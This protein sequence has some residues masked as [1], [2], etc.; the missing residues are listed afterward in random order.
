LYI[1]SDTNITDD[2]PP[3][4]AGGVSSAI[5]WPGGFWMTHSRVNYK[6]MSFDM[7]SG[8]YQNPEDIAIGGDR[9]ASVEQKH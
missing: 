1:S 5:V 2:F 7:K 4:T 9:M 6:G 8:Y 3:N